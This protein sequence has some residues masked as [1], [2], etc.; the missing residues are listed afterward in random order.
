MGG[1]GS[2][3]DDT[4]G[5][6]K[7]GNAIKGVSKKFT[8]NTFDKWIAPE[9]KDT[10][11]SI[12]GAAITSGLIPIPGLGK[13][14]DFI[15]SA[16]NLSPT[17]SNMAIGALQNPDNPVQGALM[18]GYGSKTGDF[19]RDKL[20]DGLNIGGLNLGNLME[21]NT[22]NDQID[23]KDVLKNAG[24]GYLM[25]DKTGALAGM[26]KSLIGDSGN[27]FVNQFVYGYL[28]NKQTGAGYGYTGGLANMANQVI[29]VSDLSPT[30]KSLATGASNAM[31]IQSNPL[32][33]ALAQTAEDKLEMPDGTANVTMQLLKN[34]N[35]SSGGGTATP[36]AAPSTSGGAA[37]SGTGGISNDNFSGGDVL[38]RMF[39]AS[40][41]R[42][43]KQADTLIDKI[44]DAMQR[45]GI[46]SS[47]IHQKALGEMAE[48]LVAEQS[49]VRNSMSLDVYNS[50]QQWLNAELQRNHDMQMLMTQIR[51][52]EVQGNKQRKQ[53]LLLELGNVVGQVIARQRGGGSG[54]AAPVK[55]PT[56]NPVTVGRSPDTAI[57]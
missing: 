7:V 25:N 10:L 22:L 29:A 48:N 18:Q 14:P 3:F 49:A 6:D 41:Y 38:N 47:G 42:M 2:F 33:G 46:Q 35:R 27:D 32:V 4:L 8:E 37:T 45:R 5:M 21:S 50:L 9:H 17:M 30:Q 51:S 36:V 13:F 31:G 55:Q 28:Q 39:E 20:L 34:T 57:G 16:W 15:K 11:E 43:Q 19:I 1:I 52:A 56:Y 23:W 54:Q 53:E 12:A 26:A 24:T 44:N 40:D